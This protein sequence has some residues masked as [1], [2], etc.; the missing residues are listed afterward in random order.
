MKISLNIICALAITIGFAQDNRP[1][2]PTYTGTITSMEYVPSL[3]SRMSE[4]TPPDN[5]PREARDKR[6][7]GQYL[8]MEQQVEHPDPI[9]EGTR[10]LQQRTPLDPPSLVIDNAYSSNSQPTDPS[11]A[12][13]PDHVFVVY[14]TAFVIYDKAGNV[15]LPA[16]G[17]SD[18]FPSSGCCDL[19]V[20]YDNAA[21]RWVLSFLGNGAQIAVSDGP[22]PIT[23]GWYIYTISSIS[24][25][26]KLSVWSDGY[27]LTDNTTSNNKV[28]VLERD[29]LLAGNPSTARVE[30]YNLPGI[31]TF[32]FY[33]P[34]VFNVT[35]ANLPATGGATV[36]YM[37]DDAWSNVS[38]D[39]LKMWTVTPSWSAP[40]GQGSVSAATEFAID[41][42]IGV[43]DN[44]SFANLQQPGRG[45]K[46]NIDAL[47]ATIMNQAQFRKFATHN[48]AVFNFVVDTDAS[49]GEIAGVRWFEFRQ[50]GDNQPWYKYQEGTYVAQD[51]RHAWNAS[52]A[53][54]AQG[55][56]GMG[57][58][59]MSSQS[60]SSRTYV[61]S[62]FTGQTAGAPLNAMDG[63]EQLISN[64][65]NKIPGTRYGDYSKID[66]DP[67]DGASF[68]YITE[69]LRGSRGGVIGK[70][71]IQS[72][73]GPD[74]EAPTIPTNLAVT[75][76]TENSATL[77]WSASTDN[78]GVTGY[79]VFL[80]G[81]LVDSTVNTSYDFSGL[82]TDTQYMA[83]VQAFDAAGNTSGSAMI[84]FTT[85]V[86][87]NEAPTAPSNVTASDITE[88]SARIDWGV[89]ADNVGVERYNIAVDGAFL[90]STTT[91][92]FNITGLV[93]LTTYNVEVRA[94]DAAGN[95]SAAGTVSFETLEGNTGGG[96]IAAYYFETGLQGWIDGGRNCQ[97]QATSN[98]CE[99]VQSIKLRNGG[100]SA[101]ATSPALDLTGNTQV[102][103]DM[104]I[105]ASGMESNDSFSVQISQ[106]NSYT[107]IYDSG[108]VSN[109]SCFPVSVV[110][111]STDFTFSNNNRFRVQNNG[112]KNNDVIWFD[113]VIINGDGAPFGDTTQDRASMVAQA[114]IL[115]ANNQIE[116]YP[117]PAKNALSVQF[118]AV[119]FDRVI[120]FTA[121][122]SLIEERDINETQMSFDVSNLPSG[123]YFMRFLQGKLAVT[124]RFVKE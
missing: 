115:T 20:S 63:Q 12:V 60:S 2:G 123:V 40:N 3:A 14:N 25:Y 92:T 86:I 90:G 52:L 73:T 79:N 118:G 55:N 66:V 85:L 109:G 107:T 65:N 69:Y 8:R 71:Q 98:S 78:V 1:Q 10:D 122:G 104:Q 103:L 93:A 110:L 33:S 113:E 89:S 94:E 119:R 81:I 6:S 76:I 32:G 121:T 45:R 124:K 74:E 22:D 54:D 88:N 67:S 19:T 62:Y 56:I 13:G 84:S 83:A 16:S 29:A 111:N 87:D 24:D 23:A 57:Y 95:E 35:D 105:F 27:Y 43:F 99:G 4:L 9:L 70:F 102:T 26:Q 30:A 77:N 61:S 31:R 112:N 68:W 44:G 38:N 106:G 53:M 49:S 64:G 39:H 120:M 97:L 21:D 7:F 58:S 17:P 114:K 28:W 18:I 41:P 37:Q 80:D 51:N 108:A 75:D 116:L 47:Q 34:Q 91:T 117:N 72:N 46:V 48:S 36:V 100:S 59:S 42:F 5:T 50:T 15:V 101:R 96:L 11:L 82:S